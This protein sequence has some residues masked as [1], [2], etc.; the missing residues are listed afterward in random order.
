MGALPPALEPRWERKTAGKPLVYHCRD[1][2]SPALACSMARE[3]EG[4]CAGPDTGLGSSDAVC[5]SHSVAPPAAA[6]E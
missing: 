5:S 4:G 6:E 3:A 1:R 2:A